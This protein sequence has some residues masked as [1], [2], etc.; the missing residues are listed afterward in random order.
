VATSRQTRRSGGWVRT[1]AVPVVS[2]RDRPGTE[3]GKIKIHGAR[4]NAMFLANTMRHNQRAIVRICAP[5]KLFISGFSHRHRGEPATLACSCLTRDSTPQTA[6]AIWHAMPCQSYSM[7]GCLLT[8]QR[9]GTPK[10]QH[11]HGGC[12]AR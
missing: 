7:A 9:A 4:G 10:A 8:N 12:I 2:C 11:I 5:N 6:D 1:H 3:R